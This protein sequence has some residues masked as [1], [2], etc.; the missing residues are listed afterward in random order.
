MNEGR[1]GGRGEELPP[2]LLSLQMTGAALLALLLPGL[3][4]TGALLLVDEQLGRA[5]GQEATLRSRHA[6][7]SDVRLAS[8]GVPRRKD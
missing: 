8:R 2:A 6:I 1:R 4:T 7:P 5:R 3:L